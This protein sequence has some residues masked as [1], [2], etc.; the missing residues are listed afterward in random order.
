MSI[1]TKNSAILSAALRVL[2]IG[3]VVAAPAGAMAQILP[4]TAQRPKPAPQVSA[5]KPQAPAPAASAK[6]SDDVVAH[7]GATDITTSQLR[8]YVEALG[9]REQAAIAKE[10]GL[11]SQAV[12]AML[13]ERVVLQE[14]LA[15][16]WDQQ[17][18]V[19]AQLEQ[20]RE[21]AL[22]ESYLQSVS[23]PPADYPSEEE[24]QKAYDANRSSFVVPRQFQLG[25][26]FVQSPKDADR[27]TEDKAKK[28][29][30]DI[31]RKLKSGA[32][33]AAVAKA[34]SEAKDGGELGWLAEGQ[35]RPEIRTRVMGL[36]KGAVS[37]PI[38]LDDGWHF[39]KLIDTKA[40]TTRPLAEAREQLAQQMRVE[41]AGLLRR[42]YVAELVKRNPPVV[43]EIALSN[44]LDAA[45]K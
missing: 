19:A 31:Q 39:V 40:S 17:P 2:A 41:R 13:N 38:Q 33:F 24:L 4:S 37:E 11:L 10:P 6:T 3:A 8:A 32:D 1:V 15:K 20:L 45:R 43:N 7:V 30:E 22:V 9:A 21:R 12:R 36:V 16:K 27:A 35:I 42:A 25:H 26:I 18:K 28:T 5:I 34:Q 23:V 44:I 14:A 29:L